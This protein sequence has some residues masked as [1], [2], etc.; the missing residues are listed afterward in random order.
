MMRLHHEAG[1]VLELRLLPM[2]CSSLMMPLLVCLNNTSALFVMHAVPWPRVL[3]CAF[4]SGCTESL[5]MM[6]SPYKDFPAF[7]E[8]LNAAIFG[9]DTVLSFFRSALVQTLYGKPSTG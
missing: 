3:S 4:A 9:T 7:F 2:F 5:M 6:R 8:Y 1:C